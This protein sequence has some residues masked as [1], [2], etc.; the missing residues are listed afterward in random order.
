MPIEYNPLITKSY[1]YVGGG[2]YLQISPPDRNGIRR[3]RHNILYVQ[4]ATR[5]RRPYYYTQ[6]FTYTPSLSLSSSHS[7]TQQFFHTEAYGGMNSVST[8]KAVK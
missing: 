4:L 3:S 5:Q 7:A 8:L 1:K 2:I 6:S